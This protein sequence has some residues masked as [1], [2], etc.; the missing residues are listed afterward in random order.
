[1]KNLISHFKASSLKLGK[2]LCAETMKHAHIILPDLTDPGEFVRHFAAKLLMLGLS[3]V[4]AYCGERLQATWASENVQT[5]D[6][7][8]KNGN[9]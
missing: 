2:A 6:T 4:L 1:M 5:H 7:D 8:G 3:L 9:H